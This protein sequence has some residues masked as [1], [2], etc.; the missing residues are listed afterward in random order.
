MHQKAVTRVA[1]FFLF[2]IFL[3]AESAAVTSA[4]EQM[5]SQG[6]TSDN[7]YQCRQGLRDKQKQRHTYTKTKKHQSEDTLHKDP[8]GHMIIYIPYAP[9]AKRMKYR[10]IPPQNPPSPRQPSMHPG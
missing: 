9:E 1:A 10:S 8:S 2:Y 5:I 6:Q 4:A 3:V 7:K